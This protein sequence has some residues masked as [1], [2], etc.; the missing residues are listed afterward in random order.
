MKENFRSYMHKDDF[1]NS[2]TLMH[3]VGHFILLLITKKIDLITLKSCVV[4][5]V[6]IIQF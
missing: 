2:I 5:F 3:Y 1:G 4:F 6:T